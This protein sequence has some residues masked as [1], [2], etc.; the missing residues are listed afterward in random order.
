MK[1]GGAAMPTYTTADKRTDHLY[2][3]LTDIKIRCR[4]TV[5][6]LMSNIPF[7]LSVPFYNTFYVQY[8]LFNTLTVPPAGRKLNPAIVS[9]PTTATDIIKA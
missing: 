9:G 1:I 6:F 5:I 7:L 3:Y 4:C 8:R 2:R